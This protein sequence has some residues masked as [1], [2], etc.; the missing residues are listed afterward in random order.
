MVIFNPPSV[1]DVSAPAPLDLGPAFRLFER[2]LRLLLGVPP[3]PP[4]APASGALAAWQVDALVRRRLAEATQQSLRHLDAIVQ[5]VDDIPNMRVGVEVQNGVNLALQELELVSPASGLIILSNFR[6][7]RP[8]C[9]LTMS[10]RV[11]A[12]TAG[13]RGARDVVWAGA[14]A[15]L[16]GDGVGLAGLL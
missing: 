12:S 6:A 4:G 10:S 2:Q 15:R 16:A 11:L 14:A 5:L 1:N 13:A 3:A 9:L 8:G 7:S